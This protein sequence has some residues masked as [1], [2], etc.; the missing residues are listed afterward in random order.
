[1]HNLQSGQHRQRFPTHLSPAEAK[2]L[3]FQ[4]LQTKNGIVESTSQGP[5]GFLK[6]QGRHQGAVTGLAV[7]GLNRV[8]ISC[9]DDGKVKV[10]VAPS[11]MAR[12]DD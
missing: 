8:V 3:K 6:G 7:D 4:Q 2:K 5:S 10:G 11:T 1:M 12:N 9:G